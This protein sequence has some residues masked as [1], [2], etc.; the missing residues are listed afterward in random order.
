MSVDIHSEKILIL[1]FGSQYTQLIARRVREAHVYC[2]LHPF[3]LELAAIRSFAPSGIILSGGP[4]SVYEEGAPAVAEELFE[5]G[6]P[7]LG[8]CY[9]MQLM[10]R[11]F[12]GEVVPAGKREF[13]HAEL[14][15]QGTPGPLF[16]GFFLDGKSP[17][18]MSHGDHVSQV[19]EG[20]QVAAGTA[21]AP[22]CAIQNLACNLYGVQFHPEVNHTPRGEQLIDTFVR[23]ICGCSGKW[24]PGQIIEDA[25]A[26]IKQQVGSDRVILGLSGGVD[27]S[28]AAALIHR[29]IGEQLTCVFVDN[30]L[31]RLGEG[32]QVMATFAQNLGVKVIRVDAEDRFLSALAGVSDPEKKRKII[33]GLFVEIFEEESNK[34][35]DARWLAQGTIYPDV[36]ESAGAKTGKAHNIKS[37]HNVGGLP[38]HMKLKLLEPLRELFKDEVRAIGEE[39]GL[40]HQMVWRHPFPGPGLGVRIL[41]EV[42]KDYADILRQA[43]AIY[44][45][46]LYAADH[47]HKISQA[48]AVFLPVKSV[49][50]MGD[51]RTYEYVVALR[52]VE[53]KDFMT[54]GWYPLPYEDLARISSRII[55]EVKGINRVVYDISSKPPATIEWE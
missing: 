54:A 39:L 20:F 28:V 55:N 4:K 38:E 5:L 11:H 33:G 52:A 35:T 44:I 40:P 32:D 43:D 48:F 30:G 16:D 21:N 36:I 13:G 19:P 53:T 26:R 18:W 17:V 25:V 45:E 42:R 29:A 15:A 22:V 49:G 2:E 41:G 14:L 50:V 51:G 37:H 27:S 47:Y 23:K 9:G 8:I 24:T 3:D 31:L 34:I 1:D 10:S 6:V 7:V 46:E 12:G